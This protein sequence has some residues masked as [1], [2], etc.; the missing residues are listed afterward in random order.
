MTE[1]PQPEIFPN[2]G[3]TESGHRAWYYGWQMQRARNG[4]VLAQLLVFVSVAA[5]LWQADEA[6]E[7]LAAVIKLLLISPLLLLTYWAG[8]RP[9][10]RRAFPYLMCASILAVGAA[11][12][13]INLGGA[14]S[15]LH[16]DALVL[17]TVFTYFLGGLAS[18]AASATGLAL[19]GLHIFL[20][21]QN[22]SPLEV[23]TYQSLFLLAINALGMFSAN[24]NE[25]AAR[26]AYWRY[27]TAT[28]LAEIDPL[29]SLMNRRG[30]DRAY[31]EL[32]DR[33]LKERQPLALAFVD[34]DHFKAINDALGHEAGDNALRAVAGVLTGTD[35]PALCGRIGGDEFIAVWYG[36][37]ATRAELIAARIPETVVALK[38]RN[39][40]TPLG[41]ATV[42]VGLALCQPAPGL[43]ASDCLRLA[44]KAVYSAKQAGRNRVEVA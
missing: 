14:D 2:P 16:Y 3:D 21:W 25:R 12:A 29:T 39:E 41:L 32:W 42:S 44:D 27:Q 40:A 35:Q 8:N 20:A 17:V 6:P 28:K 24:L 34:L 26:E 4:L 37:G 7:R 33:A 30:F 18:N 11:F 19:L 22:E 31:A 5:D 38:I 10:W 13:L 15:S 1:I 36:V 9:Q 43:H 23:M